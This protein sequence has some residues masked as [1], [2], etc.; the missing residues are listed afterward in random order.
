MAEF[1]NATGVSFRLE[2]L[3]DNAN[4]KLILISPYLK[5][6]DRIKSSLIDR[7]RFKIIIRLIYG[8]SELQPV[9]RNWLNVT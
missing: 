8:K 9:E 4:E 7:D 6:N 5:I 1:L 3:I 2:Q